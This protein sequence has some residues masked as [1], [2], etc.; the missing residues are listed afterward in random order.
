MAL[1]ECPECGKASLDYDPAR[2]VWRCLYLTQSGYVSEP[3]PTPEQRI[4]DLE[5]LA[6]RRGEEVSR[7]RDRV[8]A[9]EAEIRELD[10]D[11]G[12]ERRCREREMGRIA[13]LKAE[14]D[15]AQ[16]KVARLRE[17]ATS[18]LCDFHRLDMKAPACIHLEGRNDC[19]EARAALQGGR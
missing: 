15:A 8:H 13:E 2:G 4:R 6:E 14:R 17:F 3:E 18:R 9:L 12:R 10:G 7:K 19:A 11:L 16:Q 1:K 5:D